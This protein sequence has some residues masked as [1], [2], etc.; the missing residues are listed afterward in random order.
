[1]PKKHIKGEQQE[2]TRL[3]RMLL[4]TAS[5][6]VTSDTLKELATL[7]NHLRVPSFP[8]A[9]E[10]FL[11]TL[12]HF[13][14]FIMVTYKKSF[15]P[16]ILHPKDP[17]EHS[18]TL[19]L[20]LNTAYVL[21]PLFNNIQQGICGV[22]RL[23]EISPDSFKQTEYYLNCYRRFDLVDEI[24]L[25]IPLDDTT[26]CAI[27]LGRKAS[28]GSIKRQ[29]MSQLKE[30]FPLIE[31]LVKQF[32]LF[33]SRSYTDYQPSNGPIK[34]A[35]KTFARGVLTQ[36]EQEVLGLI[37]RGHSSKA[38]ANILD[39]SSGTVKVHRKNIHS[40]LDTSTQS[41]IFTLFLEHLE[42]LD[43]SRH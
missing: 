1:M 25:T 24:D 26:T 15:K 23:A 7:V 2:R 22:S 42:E 10:N 37:L 3:Q 4:N 20:Y 39:I 29:E 34:H 14:T 19:K 17:A 38:I 9:L 16:I 6:G 41:E 30:T 36:R 31:S 28:L 13:D 33:Q 32:W 5:T 40:R 18:P 27:S 35:L 8:S 21:D 43:I 12:S 11:S